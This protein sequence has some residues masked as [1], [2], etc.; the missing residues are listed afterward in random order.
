MWPRSPH[1][2]VR[3][4]AHAFIHSI[5]SSLICEMECCPAL[6]DC[7]RPSPD[8]KRTKP[9]HMDI[10]TLPGLR[11]PVASWQI[12]HTSKK[13]SAFGKA[14]PEYLSQITGGKGESRSLNYWETAWFLGI[15][16]GW[17]Q[18]RVQGF[19]GSGVWGYR[20]VHTWF[21]V[22]SFHICGFNQLQLENI[23]KRVTKHLQMFFFVITLQTI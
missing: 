5:V 15:V 22:F 7:A 21:S 19:I 11:L 17:K 18:M 3:S 6:C 14:F 10:E 20:A 9:L 23:L 2:W 8:V 13:A 1:K 16:M 12:P 4:F